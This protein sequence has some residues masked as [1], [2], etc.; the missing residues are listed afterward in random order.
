MC[1]DEGKLLGFSNLKLIFNG[2][3][4]NALK[5]VQKKSSYHSIFKAAFHD[6]FTDL[7]EKT[8]SDEFILRKIGC[9]MS[10]KHYRFDYR[11]DYKVNPAH[12]SAVLPY[13]KHVACQFNKNSGLNK[14]NEMLYWIIKDFSLA[15]RLPLPNAY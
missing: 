12:I 10:R 15:Q 2:A 5:C 3:A 8:A 11:F 1:S 6:V 7:G 4:D 14:M 13:L 9:L